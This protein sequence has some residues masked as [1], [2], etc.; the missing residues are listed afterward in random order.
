MKYILTA[1]IGT[2]AMKA[3]IY[4]GEG[5]LA[6]STTREYAFEAPAPGRAELS[7]GIYTGTFADAVRALLDETKIDAADIA[8][9]GFSTQGET[10]LLLDGENRPLRPAILWCD[11]RATEEAAD[12]S[13]R[14]GADEIQAR[15]GQVGADAIWP[16]AKLLWVRRHE[17]ETF[18]KIEKIVQ[19]E[20]WFSLLLTGRAYGEDSILGSSIYYDIRTRAWWPEMLSYIGIRSEQLPE[21]ALPGAIIGE[22]TEEAAARFGL[23]AGTQV[24]I[25]GIDVAVGAVGVGNIRPGNFSDVTGSA[26][27]TMA[28]TDHIILDP[29]MEMPCYCSAVPGL[30]MIHA[31][32]SGGI[33]LRWYRDTFRC[34][35]SGG[36]IPEILS[37][38]MPGDITSD[39]ASQCISDGIAP[40]AS[41]GEPLFCS[42]PAINDYDLMDLLAADCPPGA[43]GLIALPHLTGSGPPDLC[44]EMKGSLIGLSTA[45]GQKHIIRAFM[46]GVAMIL[47]RVLDAT[48]SL[49]LTSDRI[50]C[51]GGGAKSPVWCQ[52]KADA[53]GREVV[54][55]ADSEN[56]GCLGAAMLA[57]TA[58]GMFGSL[59][60]AVEKLVREDQHY[61]PDPENAR[62]YSELRGRY[63]DLM[64]CLKPLFK[65]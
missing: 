45:H 42:T 30:Y 27:C 50:V 22:V 2:T 34:G 9:I 1:D 20:G 26:L 35:L 19:L 43:D 58:A 5:R 8:V 41:P 21:I 65:G 32:A 44:P 64:Q 16:G 11:T 10:M 54:T 57:G 40:P 49:G 38:G 14:F 17:P 28:M 56:V 31:Y 52:I 15:T 6:A 46:E 33:C 37:R 53:T 3:A 24:S 7:A 29:A 62:V 13:E 12:I 63:F 60:E 47:C 23:A 51:L 61:L 48:E 39:A 25:G 59:E 4:S 36:T 55:T 18:A